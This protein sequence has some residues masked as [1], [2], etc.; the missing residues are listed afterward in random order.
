MIEPEPRPGDVWMA[1]VGAARRRAACVLIREE[2]SGWL[3]VG[4]TTSPRYS[5]GT[6]RTQIKAMGG[7]KPS[8][9]WSPKLNRVLRSDLA[10]RVGRLDAT[11]VAVVAATVPAITDRDRAAMSA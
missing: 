6:Q 7:G 8:F 5:D 4:L 2:T 9:I 3:V 1:F 10:N 11:A